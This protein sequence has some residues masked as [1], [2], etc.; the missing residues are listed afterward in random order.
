MTNYTDKTKQEINELVAE[1][2]GHEVNVSEVFGQGSSKHTYVSVKDASRGSYT[3]PDYC[4]S[5][6]NAGELIEKY[7]IALRPAGRY[8]GKSR[9]EDTWTANHY[10]KDIYARNDNPTRA[11]AECFLMMGDL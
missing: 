7:R 11:V 4:N 9:P 6:A 1:R 2:L 10:G 3:L 8:K 5:W